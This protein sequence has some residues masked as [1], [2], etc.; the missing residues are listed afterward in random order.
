LVDKSINEYTSIYLLGTNDT[1]IMFGF[2]LYSFF[3][4][5]TP[6][7]FYKFKYGHFSGKAI[8]YNIILSLIVAGLVLGAWILLAIKAY[9][10][11]FYQL[12]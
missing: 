1:G 6:F 12:N 7:I 3:I 8:V 10:E 11:M 5:T 9:Q 4:V 2:F